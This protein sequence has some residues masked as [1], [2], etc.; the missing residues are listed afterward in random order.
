MMNIIGKPHSLHKNSVYLLVAVILLP[1]IIFWPGWN[2]D[3]SGYWLSVFRYKNPFSFI[4]SAYTYPTGDR[5]CPLNVLGS[6]LLSYLSFSPEAFSIYNYLLAL[7]STSMLLILCFKLFPKFWLLPIFILFT[8]GFT[9]SYYRIY[10]GE[11]ELLFLWTLF[12]VLFLLPIIKN[13]SKPSRWIFLSLIPANLALYFK[14]P[15]FIMLGFFSIALIVRYIFPAAKRNALIIRHKCSVKS[16]KLLLFLLIFSA[17]LFL[18]QYLIFTQL[19]SETSYLV[20]LTPKLTLLDRLMYS[21]K[22]FVLFVISDPLLTVVLPLLLITTHIFSNKL[23][24]IKSKSVS[25]SLNI[26]II[27]SLAIASLSFLF[28]YVALGIQRNHYLLPAYPF[29]I[30]AIAGYLSIVYPYCLKVFH[31]TLRI[32]ISMV[33][34]IL[35]VNSMFS[36][37]NE[38]YFHRVSSRNF[39][40]YNKVLMEKIQERLQQ[41]NSENEKIR[42]FL[43]GKIDVS[44]ISG[45]QLNFLRFYETSVSRVEILYS[46]TTQNWL[47]SESDA[48]DKDSGTMEGDLILITPNS[49]IS[50]EKIMANLHGLKLREIMCTESPYYFEI[51]EIRHLLKYIM[52]RNNPDALDSQMIFREVDFAIYEVMKIDPKF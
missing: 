39:M 11:R 20:S 33:V 51:P 43:P 24:T 16:I 10:H 45:I 14:E 27:D 12:L 5:F 36:S 17:V 50:Q 38:M 1:I 44:Y 35:V 6:H 21:G 48:G 19:I 41:Q 25:N 28:T 47:L 52:L 34:I 46:E 8:P 18:I 42:I 2:L 49:N 9:A 22:A 4:S 7:L 37:F 31:K 26:Q 23:K 30:L 40:Q 15:G 29:A 13:P 3:D 32:S